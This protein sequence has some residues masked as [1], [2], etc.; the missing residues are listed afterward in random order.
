MHHIHFFNVNVEKISGFPQL[1]ELPMS[2]N[3]LLTRI[4]I[5]KLLKQQ[6]SLSM[7]SIIFSSA[8]HLS[9][10]Q[11][12]SWPSW[13]QKSSRFLGSRINLLF[14]SSAACWKYS[15]LL[16]THSEKQENKIKTT[17]TRQSLF[18]LLRLYLP[19]CRQS[20][21][22]PSELCPD[23]VLHHFHGPQLIWLV[24]SVTPVHI[25]GE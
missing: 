19:A 16:D 13:N 1:R 3:I 22:N 18:H 4:C 12:K 21:P 5:I 6:W 9:H 25:W 2:L 11:V 8:Q 10:W 24:L 17:P 23:P 15:D 7:E 20:K 14:S